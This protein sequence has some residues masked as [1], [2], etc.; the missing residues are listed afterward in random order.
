MTMTISVV[1]PTHNCAGLVDQAIASIRRQTRPVE[2]VIVVDDASADGT[3]DVAESLGVKVIRLT[4][5]AGPSSARNHGVSQATGD[6]IA[7]LDAD[8]LWEAEHCEVLGGLLEVAPEAALAFT[9]M[10]PFWEIQGR[11]HE[12]D[13]FFDLPE[14]TPCDAFRALVRRNSIGTSAVMMRHSRFNEL[15]GFDNAMRFSEDYDLWLRAARCW[16][17]IGT[18]KWTSRRRVHGAQTSHRGRLALV[19]GA[20]LA[21]LRARTQP[22]EACVLER[23]ESSL[24]EAYR[25]AWAW[26]WRLA[27]EEQAVEIARFLVYE[28]ASDV[29]LSHET[30]MARSAL[31]FGWRP[32][33][34]ARAISRRI[35]KRH[36]PIQE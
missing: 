14:E 12:G 8:D 18:P 28:V 6:C 29:L 22:A 15:G 35:R 30:M 32:W 17:I 25:A 21:R 7:F 11:V 27:W 16:P 34:G 24:G 36:R 10:L 1:I 31:R 5:N 4:Q 20:W 23:S 3:A 33:V 26:D 13:A 19:Q 2:E 9:R